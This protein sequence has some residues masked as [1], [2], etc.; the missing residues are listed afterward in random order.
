MEGKLAE[1]N[2]GVAII[3]DIPTNGRTQKYGNIIVL[4]G[5]KKWVVEGYR[6]RQ[7]STISGYSISTIRRIIYTNLDRQPRVKRN[8]NKYKYL[9]L[10]GTYLTNHKGIFIVMDGITKE[11]I[12][13]RFNIAENAPSLLSFFHQLKE[14]G[15][16]PTIDGNPAIKRA[17]VSVCGH[18]SLSS[19]VW[20]IYN[21]KDSVGV[22]WFPSGLMLNIYANCSFK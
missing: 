5:F 6:Y 9:I 14:Q 16:D 15:L 13:S 2:V 20:Y 19:A 18:Q 17:L 7:I 10:D 1:D 3:A 12:A 4:Y 8:L 11:V 22:V 21:A